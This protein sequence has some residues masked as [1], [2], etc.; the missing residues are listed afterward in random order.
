MSI[1]WLGSNGGGSLVDATVASVSADDRGFT[2]G[3]GV[4]ETMTARNGQIFA[5]DRHIK[6]LL[7][8]AEILQLPTPNTELVLQAIDAT[9]QANQDSLN[10]VTRVRVTY[11]SGKS[12]EVPTLLVMCAPQPQWPETTTAITVPWVRNERSA[13]VGAKSTSYVE[14]LVALKAAQQRH[15]SE[16]LL[17]NTIGN[18]CEGT[19]SNVFV[20]IEGKVI[21]PPLS[22][23][24]LPGVTRELVLEW[25]DG[26]ER[27]VPFEELASVQEVFLTS[28]TRG[29]HPVVELDGRTLEVGATTSL[30][31]TKFQECKE[32]NVNP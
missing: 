18:L 13:I 14:N 6:R 9:L 25:F 16:A 11:T 2:V 5:L 20:V 29:I 17:A 3:D 8:S 32:S 12:G 19:T 15:A 26:E 4:F 31:R 21:T 24:C 28:S 22:S 27:N 10:E 7:Q 30:M 1:H 23:G